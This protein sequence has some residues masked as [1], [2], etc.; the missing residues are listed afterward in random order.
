MVIGAATGGFDALG[1]H[2]YALSA[3][4]TVPRN[5]LDGAVNYTY[6]R[7]WP[8]LFAGASDDTDS[9]RVGTVRSREVTAGVLLPWRQVRWSSSLLAAASASSD[10]FDCADCVEPVD[11]TRERQA[12]RLGVNFSTAKSFGYSVSAEEGAAFNLI[13]E[14]ARGAGGVTATSVAAEARGYLPVFP[15]HA[16]I[17]ARVAAAS[18]HGDDTVRRDFSASGSGPQF[19]GFDIGLDAIGLLRGFDSDDLID[20]QAAVLNLDYRFP[21]ARPQRGV[22]TW[23]FFLRTIHGAAFLDIGQAWD[24]DFD[25]AALR[26]SVGGELSF[27]VVLGSALPLTIATGAAWRH[28]P[29]RSQHGGAF[30]IRLGRAF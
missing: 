14:L 16:V 25:R 28:D 19:G 10:D 26:R 8:T 29:G 6:A 2:N 7:W 5:R 1:R 30:F 4:W 21:I 12:G 27:D 23:P 15:R 9:W 18:S 20:R 13:T 17:A 24:D 22:G 11:V 3:G